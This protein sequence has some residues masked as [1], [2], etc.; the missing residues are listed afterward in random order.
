MPTDINPVVVD[1]FHGDTVESFADLKGAGILGVIHKATQG[2]TDV[3]PA[4]ASRRNEAV[5]AG[6]LWGAYHFLTKEDP[7]QQAAFFVRNAAPDAS[8][9]L[10]CDH[11]TR[12]VSLADAIGFMKAVEA[13]VGRQCVLYSGFLLKEQI[14]GASDD[15]ASW[16]ASRRSWLSEYGSEPK[17]P[18]CWGTAPWLWQYTGDGIGPDPHTLA[19][20]KGE[21]DI[22]SFAGSADDLASQWAGAAV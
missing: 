2:L 9:L 8:T 14:D 15:Q 13:Q 11:E 21:I 4:Y 17:C 1:I 5:Q 12:G 20:L 10:A 16:L 19:G 22:N 6:L 7:S 3:D 18:S